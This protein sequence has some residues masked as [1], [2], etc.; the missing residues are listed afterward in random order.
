MLQKEDLIH[1][2]DQPVLNSRKWPRTLTM[3]LLYVLLLTM[4]GLGGY[5]VGA[6]QQQSSSTDLLTKPK[7]SWLPS[8]KPVQQL[9][10]TPTISF[11]LTSTSNPTTADWET[12]RDPHGFFSIKYPSD[13][14]IQVQYMKEFNPRELITNVVVQR[15]F[16]PGSQLDN[17]ETFYLSLS[18]IGNVNHITTD[19]RKQTVLHGPCA[20]TLKPY[21]N[22][23][24]D[25]LYYIDCFDNYRQETIVHITE[26]KIYEFTFNTEG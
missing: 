4:F 1:Q 12:Y 2:S 8:T 19:E 9:S 7:P 25:G 22:G 17:I 24:I 21:R 14:H 3:I 5:W 18:V 20:N 10:V 15:S 11:K 23:E 26:A 6:R 13:P 16:E